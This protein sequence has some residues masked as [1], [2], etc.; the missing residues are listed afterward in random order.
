MKAGIIAEGKG[1]L[2]S[3]DDNRFMVIHLDT[4]ERFEKNYEVAEPKREQTEGYVEQVR[5]GVKAKIVEWLGQ[6][7]DERITFAVAVE[8]TDAW[9]LTIFEKKDETGF[10]PRPKERLERKLNQVL[11]EKERKKHFQSDVFHQNYEIS[12]PFRNPKKVAIARR[13]NKSLDL[14]CAAL[15]K[16]SGQT[17]F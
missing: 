9:L 6:H 2:D 1:F 13:H 16:L 12:K 15:E 4:A 8:E 17:N 14:F 11:P 10:Y 5:E 7:S 3:F